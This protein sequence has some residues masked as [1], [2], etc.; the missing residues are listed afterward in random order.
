MWSIQFYKIIKLI[1][2]F[3]EVFFNKKTRLDKLRE[4]K[5]LKATVRN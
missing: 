2:W 1:D 4:M 3:K 5:Y